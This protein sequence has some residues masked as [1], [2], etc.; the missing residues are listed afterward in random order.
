MRS[1]LV[2]AA[3]PASETSAFVNLTISSIVWVAEAA[4][5]LSGRSV[6]TVVIII[7]NELNFTNCHLLLL[8]FLNFGS[9]VVFSIVVISTDDSLFGWLN[10][11][12]NSLIEATAAAE[13]LKHVALLTVV[14]DRTWCPL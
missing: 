14:S 10:L 13:I 6:I 4:T 1:S 5:G 9:E 11:S 2:I 7:R 8:T 3:A 12:I